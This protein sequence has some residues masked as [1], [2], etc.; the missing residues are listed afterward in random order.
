MCGDVRREWSFAKAQGNVEETLRAW[1]KEGEPLAAMRLSGS[2]LGMPGKEALLAGSRVYV[3]QPGPLI[4]SIQATQPEPFQGTP[5]RWVEFSFLSVKFWL[6][7]GGDCSHASLEARAFLRLAPVNINARIDAQVDGEALPKGSLERLSGKVVVLSAEH[8]ALKDV[9]MQTIV[10][11]AGG[12]V[13]YDMARFGLAALELALQSLRSP[14]IV[15]MVSDFRQWARVEGTRKRAWDGCTWPVGGAVRDIEGS[16]QVVVCGIAAVPSQI[17][18]LQQEG[19][20]PKVS[21]NVVTAWDEEHLALGGGKL[22]FGEETS[23]EEVILVDTEIGDQL[24][25]SAKMRVADVCEGGAKDLQTPG[26]MFAGAGVGLRGQQSYSTGAIGFAALHGI[27]SEFLAVLPLST[28]AVRAFGMVRDSANDEPDTT[29]ERAFTL[30]ADQFTDWAKLAVERVQKEGAEILAQMERGG[31]RQSL[32][33]LQASVERPLVAHYGDPRVLRRPFNGFV[34]VPD[35][36]FIRSTMRLND[37]EPTDP[38]TLLPKKPRAAWERGAS[39]GARVGGFSCQVGGVA[40]RNEAKWAEWVDRV[41][42]KLEINWNVEPKSVPEAAW[43]MV[44]A[45]MEQLARDWGL[46]D[47]VRGGHYRRLVAALQFVDWSEMPV[48]DVVK[49]IGSVGKL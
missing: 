37:W 21:L 8:V 14:A 13:P 24:S 33:E 11:L 47:F 19:L 39:D 25:A 28:E 7:V 29:V 20:A 31:V 40:N 23:A 12:M 42:Q 15:G 35:V 17:E 44:A 16:V 4:S 46:L 26:S 22:W 30:F 3:Y 2:I 27:K 48:E 1:S 10:V 49:A 5:S 43:G 32:G 36:R 9:S 34:G 41:I 18:A 38:M 6:T 45:L